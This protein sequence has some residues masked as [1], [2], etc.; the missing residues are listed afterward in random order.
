MLP[1]KHLSGAQKRK[2]RKQEDQ[3]V[4]SQ[5]GALHKFFAVSSNAEVSPD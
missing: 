3:F 4:E 1:K 5:R 2:K